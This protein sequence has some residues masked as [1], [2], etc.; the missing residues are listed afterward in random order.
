MQ[1]ILRHKPSHT[2]SARRQQETNLHLTIDACLLL[3]TVVAIPV[4]LR[5]IIKLYYNQ[6]LDNQTIREA[7]NLWT[8]SRLQASII[9]GPI[10]YWDTSQVT[11]M[12]SLF[13]EKRSFND[14]INNWDLSNVI[15]MSYMFYEASSFNQPL[16]SWNTSNVT[17]MSFMFS[18][19]NNYNQPLNNWNTSNVTNM[20]GMFY[21]AS[22]YNQ[23][24]DS[25]IRNN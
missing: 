2:S 4:E 8:T 21:K 12:N 15:N 17:N 25:Q 14:N 20:S 1:T 23:P 5:T 9:Y 6:T 3:N 16:D 24:L 22:S 10:E 11:D 13:E 18:Y 7:V 19:A